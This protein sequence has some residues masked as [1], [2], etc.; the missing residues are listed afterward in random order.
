MLTFG[1]TDTGKTITGIVVNKRIIAECREIDETSAIL[2]RSIGGC[3]PGL[4]KDHGQQARA[5]ENFAGPVDFETPRPDLPV[6]FLN[7]HKPWW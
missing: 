6:H 7:F 5:S 1:S 3:S 2:Y 4:M